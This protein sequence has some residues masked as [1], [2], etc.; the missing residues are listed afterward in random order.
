MGADGGG[1]I[2]VR[3][4]GLGRHEVRPE[5]VLAVIVQDG[6]EVLAVETDNERPVIGDD[7]REQADAEQHEKDP[8]RVEAAAMRAEGREA[9]TVE[10][11]DP[12]PRGERAPCPRA[13][14]LYR[15]ALKSMRGS[16]TGV[17]DVAHDLHD[18]AEEREHVQG[19]E[20]HTG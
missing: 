20:H 1:D 9:A 2:G 13:R 5:A 4:V 16:T 15:R 14:R 6:E 8:E 17:E 10:R 19:A 3:V 12:G 18:Q 11:R 7:P